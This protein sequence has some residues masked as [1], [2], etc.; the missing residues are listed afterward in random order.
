[1]ITDSETTGLD[2]AKE[3][4]IEVGALLYDMEADAIVE[5]Y[6]SFLPSKDNACEHINHIPPAA[7]QKVP[8]FQLEVATDNLIGMSERAD[9]VIA[10]NAKFDRG[11]YEQNGII[12]EADWVCSKSDLTYP[13]NH[14]SMRLGHLCY[15]FDI[16]VFNAHTAIGDCVILLELVKKVPN[17]KDQ[18]MASKE[19]KQLYAA[20]VT[21]DTKEKAKAQGFTWDKKLK[22]WTKNLS[23]TEVKALQSQ[24]LELK[25]I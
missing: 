5:T 22:M 11:F 24:G 2:P 25:A 13:G 20:Q 15:D 19:P 9:F 8:E 14:K 21:F 3:K 12:L 6:Q 4:L 18:L 1:M 23:D 16:P 17:L 7:L 10:H